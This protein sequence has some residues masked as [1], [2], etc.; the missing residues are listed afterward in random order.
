[1]IIAM[2]ATT[3]TAFG[4][5]SADVIKSLE[6]AKVNGKAIPTQYV[7][8]T[9]T[10]LASNTFTAA[11]LDTINAAI[12]AGA[13]NKADAILKATA[14]AKAVGITATFGANDVVTLTDKAGRTYSSAAPA[15]SPLK[16]TV[17]T[18][19]KT[20]YLQVKKNTTISSTVLVGTAAKGTAT[21]K[22]SK[23]S[24]ATVSKTGKI[25]GKKAGKATITIT[26]PTGQVAKVTVNV[27][28]KAKKAKG[29]S[30]TVPKT[31]KVKAN[32]Y[33]TKIAT[34][35]KATSTGKATFKT[36]NKKVATVSAKGVITGK[37]AGKAKITI[38]YAGKTV[39]KTITVKK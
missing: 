12:K 36:S 13:T 26:A 27:V 9:K 20:I 31:V 29:I 37:K 14:A 24:V 32:A 35:S 34:K 39:T 19:F 11:Q 28:K 3:V 33:V 10:V 8:L 16:V 21:Y 4:A 23:T 2:F 22:S 5:T 38:K 7:T 6:S 1:V 15:V 30:A 25:V 18:A 17:K